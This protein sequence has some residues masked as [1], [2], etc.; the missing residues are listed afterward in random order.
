MAN[1]TARLIGTVL[2]SWLYQKWG[3]EVCLW[4][5]TIFI[6]TTALIS[7]GLPMQKQILIKGN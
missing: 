4:L 7:A 3:L 5:S 6:L 2:S 1:A